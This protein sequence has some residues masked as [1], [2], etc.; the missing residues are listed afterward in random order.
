MGGHPDVLAYESF[1]EDL[2]DRVLLYLA[3][4]RNKRLCLYDVGC[5]SGRLHLRYAMKTTSVA[6]L[7][8]ADAQELE[9]T[10]SKHPAFAYDPLLAG[11]LVSLG[12]IDF[13]AQMLELAKGKFRNSGLGSLLDHKAFFDH[14]SAFNLQSMGHDPF[15]LVVSVCNSVG[16]MQGPTGAVELFKA[17]RRAVEDGGGIAII[18]GYRREMVAAFAL[19]NYESTMDV[20]GQ[21]RWLTPD[22]YAAPPYV[23][24]PRAYKRAHS[25]DNKV[26]VDI[27]GPDG[28]IVKKEHVLTRDESAVRQTVETGHI[29]TY[30]DYTSRWYAFDAFDTWIKEHWSPL[31]SYHIAGK[32]IDALRGEPMQ[33]A[34]LDIN[35]ELE[36]LFERWGVFTRKE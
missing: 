10:R 26:V 24:L 7:Q 22:E 15:P 27:R 5:G 32:D 3:R 16:V 20:S 35:G 30:T 17:M 23:Q 34:I 19:G 2:L 12:G 28:T 25:A 8:P 1:E 4:E 33:M 13:S 29:C 11:Q 14:G 31:T 21:P 36:G 6:Q 9:R 18:S